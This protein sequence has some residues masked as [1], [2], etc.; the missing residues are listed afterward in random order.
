LDP[1]AHW[2]GMC[3]LA[4]QGRRL[5]H[6]QGR[7]AEC[8]ELMQQW[9]AVAE[10]EDDRAVLSEAAREMVW[11]LEGWGRVEEAERLEYRR[12]TEFEEQMKLF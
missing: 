5:A 11:I 3:S 7:I 1:A 6:E 10:E 9:Y 8:F 2:A 12:V 4:R